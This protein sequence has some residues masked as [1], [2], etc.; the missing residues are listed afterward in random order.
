MKTK[1]LKRKKK[2]CKEKRKTHVKNGVN[3]ENENKNGAITFLC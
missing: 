1:H 3:D 2:V